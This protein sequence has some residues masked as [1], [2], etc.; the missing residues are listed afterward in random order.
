MAVK[1]EH[2]QILY[3]NLY[4]KALYQASGNLLKNC[5]FM[6]MN[7]FVFGCHICSFVALV[8]LMN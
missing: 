5:F 1:G 2:F 7:I 6:M 8:K 3:R 4:F